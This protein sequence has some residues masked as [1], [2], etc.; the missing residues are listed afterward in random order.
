[1]AGLVQGQLAGCIKWLP[2][3]DELDGS[4]LDIEEGC[5]DHPVVVISTRPRNGRVKVLIVTSFGGRGLEDKFPKA[6]PWRL[7][8]LP[9][10]PSDAHPDNGIQLVLRDPSHRLRKQSYVKTENKQSI[11]LA[12]LQPYNNHGP[13]IFL[14][15]QSYETLVKYI[16][17][18]ESPDLPPS[19]ALAGVHAVPDYSHGPGLARP[20]NYQR[21]G[22]EEDVAFVLDYGT[23]RSAELAR[24]AGFINET[25]RSYFAPTPSSAATRATRATRQ[26]LLP[27]HEEYRPVVRGS[28]STLP[29]A[30]P[31]GADDGDGSAG[32]SKWQKLWYCMK[33]LLG[34]CLCLGI[35][36]GL[37]RAGYWVFDRLRDMFKSVSG[38]SQTSRLW[39]SFL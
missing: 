38:R 19:H 36:Y 20:V 16:R 34:I 27:T 18:N 37:Y 2:P 39:A 28:Y 6:G 35:T 7:A 24:P 11:R 23:R 32:S 3:K 9:I 12:S 31:A 30:R 4:D 1:M 22:A 15:K 21:S 14:S 10:A 13:D 5:C 25:P 26:P 17:F 33:I 8:H 29:T